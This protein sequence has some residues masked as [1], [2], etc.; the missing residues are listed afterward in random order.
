MRFLLVLFISFFVALPAHAVVMSVVGSTDQD[1]TV[2]NGDGNFVLRYNTLRQGNDALR[3]ADLVDRLNVFAIHQQP[4]SG[5]PIDDGQRFEDPGAF[6]GEREYWCDIDRNP[7]P[8]DDVNATHLC[9]RADV[10]SDAF[11]DA[12]GVAIVTIRRSRDCV[13]D[14]TFPSCL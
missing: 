6:Q 9:S 11:F 12:N 5:L 1:I 13:Q 10:V 2:S 14:P 3:A 8:G 4:L 7:T